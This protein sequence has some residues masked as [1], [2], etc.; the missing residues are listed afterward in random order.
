MRN[1]EHDEQCTRCEQVP[2]A[3]VALDLLGSGQAVRF[4]AR[5]R[6]MRPFVR[7]GDVLT[8]EPVA[9]ACPRRGDIVFYATPDGAAAHRLL[10]IRREGDRRMALTRGDVT[11]LW[12]ETVEWADL[13]GT[14]VAVHRGGRRVLRRTALERLTGLSWARARGLFVRFRLAGSRVKRVLRGQ[15]PV[16]SDR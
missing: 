8:I 13:C 12:T 4:V 10:A 1:A 14:V 6:S 9:K 2:L 3:R 11:G 16:I 5:G 15:W 7:D